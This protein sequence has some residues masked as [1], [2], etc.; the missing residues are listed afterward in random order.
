M[1]SR[2]LLHCEQ[3]ET[4]DCPSVSGGL[5]SQLSAAHEDLQNALGKQGLEG[6]YAIE[7][8]SRNQGAALKLLQQADNAILAGANILHI[9]LEGMLEKDGM[10]EKVAPAQLASAPPA[11]SI[12]ARGVAAAEFFIAEAEISAA[13]DMLSQKAVGKRQAREVAVSDEVLKAKRAETPGADAKAAL[14]A[15]ELPQNVVAEA[16]FDT[17]AA[18]VPAGKAKR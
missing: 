1:K 15:L 4:R 17:G 16:L 18:K 8:P 5:A 14:K 9:P 6:A 2:S 11:P 12:L 10:L 3:L 7:A 13:E